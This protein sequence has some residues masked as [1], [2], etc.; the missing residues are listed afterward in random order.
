MVRKIDEVLRNWKEQKDRKVLLVRGARQVGKTFSIR[1]FG[2]TFKHFVEINCERDPEVSNFFE[3]SLDPG[4][5]CPKLAIYSGKPITPGQTLLFFDE[6]Q[7]CPAALRSLRFFHEQ[8][9]RLHVIAAGSLLEFALEEIPSFGVGRISSVFM[10]PI[11]F[12][13]FLQAINEKRLADLMKDSILHQP[14]DEV[15]HSK[16]LDYL[17]IH[18][19]LGGMPAVVESYRISGDILGCQNILDDLLLTIRDDFAKYK[20]R[21][22][23][24]KLNEVMNAIALQAGAKFKYTN[25]APGSSSAGFKDA[26]DLL[27]RAGLAYKV[28]HT[29]AHGIPLGGQIDPQKFKVLP[30]DSGL[31]Q[32]MAGLALSDIIVE[33]T[34]RLVNEGPLAELYAGIQ[35]IAGS[36]AN[37]PPNIYYWHRE[38]RASNAEVDYVISSGKTIFGIEVKAATSGR[39]QSLRRFLDEDL[40]RHGIRVSHENSA[41][42]NNIRVV[43]LYAAELLSQKL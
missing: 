15:F 7:A 5:I 18:M 42:I 38:A 20:K 32:R 12:L 22:P 6:I 17:R 33:K 19:I 36:P 31:Y 3:G 41:E 25:I 23:V 29:S 43:P 11:S 30:F 10:Y 13:E 16:L 21:A 37:M 26:L 8:I 28:F 35:L 4:R 34:L 24:I 9:P 14:I 2:K 39:M 27:V 1:E 40:R